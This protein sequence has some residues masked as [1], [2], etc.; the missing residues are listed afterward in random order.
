MSANESASASMMRTLTTSTTTYS[1]SYPK[2]GFPSSMANLGGSPPCTP[3]A[4]TACLVDQDLACTAQPCLRESYQ[5]S[6]T[7]IGPGAPA[8][9]TDFVL[10]TTAISPTAGGKD[11]CVTQDGVVRFQNT[12]TPPTAAFTTVSACGGLAPL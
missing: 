10:F 5:Y 8:P 7:G 1:I 9:N 6:L 12:S 11:Y 4:A 3:S 2:N